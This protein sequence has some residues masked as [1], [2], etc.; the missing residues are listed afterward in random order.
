MLRLHPRLHAPV[1]P[2]PSRLLPRNVPPMPPVH[3]R[4][5]SPLVVALL[6]PIPERDILKD[7]P[8]PGQVEL[9]VYR[10][11][12]VL[13]VQHFFGFLWQVVDVHFIV[14]INGRGLLLGD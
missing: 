4:L 9:V 3:L 5:G 12:G 6:E 1:N 10:S 14:V 13:K 11:Q 7:P 2:H 8:E